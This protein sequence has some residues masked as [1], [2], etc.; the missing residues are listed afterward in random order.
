MRHLERGIPARNVEEIQYGD[1]WRWTH[2]KVMPNMLVTILRQLGNERG[3]LMTEH[4]IDQLLQRCSNL[5]YGQELN[6]LLNQALELAEESKD[7]LAEYRVRLLQA[8]ACAMSGDSIGLLGNFR[9]C[10]EHYDQ[11]PQ[12]YPSDPGDGADLLWQYKWM[13]AVLSA[14]PQIPAEEIHGI[15]EE[16]QVQYHRAGI[17][18]AAVLTARFEAAF[19]NGWMEQASTIFTQL[20]EPQNDD[21]AHCDACILSL[22]MSYLLA[23]GQPDEALSLFDELLANDFNCGQEPANAIAAALL[24][25]LRAGRIKETKTLHIRSYQAGR[26]DLDN[27]GLVAHNL[28]YLVVTGNLSR[29]L[30]IAERHLTWLAHDPMAQ[31]EHLAFLST[32]GLLCD[33]VTAAG[34]GEITLRGSENPV[35]QEFFGVHETPLALKVLGPLA[36][37]AARELASRFDLRNGNDW[38]TRGIQ[39]IA[40]LAAER[41]ELTWED[42]AWLTPHPPVLTPQSAAAYLRRAREYTA[43]GQT[44]LALLDTIAG[45]GLHPAAELAAGLH[46]LAMVLELDAGREAEAEIHLSQYRNAL[47]EAGYGELAAMLAH[48]GLSMHRDGY[49]EQLSALLHAQRSAHQDLTTRVYIETWLA[50]AQM[51]HDHFE[52]AQHCATAAHH[53]ALELLSV[54]ASDD[55]RDSLLHN[56]YSLRIILASETSSV[57]ELGPLVDSWRKFNPTDNSLAQVHY[58]LAQLALEGSEPETGLD[59]AERALAVFAGYH[60]RERAILAADFSA[61]LLLEANQADRAKE[62]LRFGLHQ[63]Q[64][65]ES[66]QRLA[67][68]FRLA[69]LHVENGEPYEA[70]DYLTQVLEESVDLL[71]ATEQAEIHDLLGDAHGLSEQFTQ[72]ATSWGQAVAFFATAGNPL[73]ELQC[74]EKLVNIHLVTGNFIEAQTLAERLVPLGDSLVSDHGIHPTLN[75]LMLLATVQ[76]TTGEGDAGASFTSAMN[77]AEEHGQIQL[78]AQITVKYAQWVGSAENFGQAVS[79]MLQSANLFEQVHQESNAAQGIGA[80]A[81]YLALAGRH[82]EA[83]LLFD[84]SLELHIEDPLAERTLRLRLADSL[85][86][87]DKPDEAAQQRQR[88]EELAK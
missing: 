49:P 3:N 52:L 38:S 9:W 6:E 13:A 1:A 68:L 20:Q 41:W 77:L 80:A 18:A 71:G 43:C 87:L 72:A 61:T 74:A 73:R 59:L 42:D 85:E 7:T 69:Q 62:R 24:P 47:E 10:L 35:L 82:E 58:F 19:A 26:K 66:N 60:D 55:V 17:G 32:L 46:Q 64:L 34:L 48:Y 76:E 56:L 4:H 30:N 27:L 75:A 39:K 12:T 81:S 86:K 21:Y 16:M 67:L 70:T 14:D 15:L 50:H 79:L 83:M 28:Q 25:L 40:G 57:K 44:A 5:P 51:R 65:A 54:R 53:G 78:Q 11:D 84:Q 63:A 31:R 37:T 45:L 2:A 22:R 23:T 29:A 8:D 36:W 88:A 33:Q